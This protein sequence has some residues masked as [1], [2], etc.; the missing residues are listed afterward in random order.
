MKVPSGRGRTMGE[1]MSHPSDVL[2]MAWGNVVGSEYQLGRLAM[3]LEVI[4][5]IRSIEDVPVL[6]ERCKASVV[7]ALETLIVDQELEDAYTLYAE[8]CEW[9]RLKF[10]SVG[11]LPD[12]SPHGT[13]VIDARLLAAADE[14][15]SPDAAPEATDSRTAKTRAL[16]ELHRSQDASPTSEPKEWLYEVEQALSSAGSRSLSDPIELEDTPAQTQLPV[17]SDHPETSGEDSDRAS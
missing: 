8:L 6:D 11:E 15:S 1:F 2:L 13:G 10:L 5:S 12:V 16:T 9:R 3:A 7:A 17:D 14:S 4:T